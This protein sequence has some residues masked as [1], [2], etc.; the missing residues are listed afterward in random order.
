MIIYQGSLFE[1][2]QSDALI[3]N[4][5]TMALV[6][7][8]IEGDGQ[9]GEAREVARYDL[10]NRLRS[11]EEGPDGAVWIAEDGEEGRLLKLTPR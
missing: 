3:A 7:V 4:L 8:D 1:D 10:G 6:V 11:I 2:W 9:N 5:A